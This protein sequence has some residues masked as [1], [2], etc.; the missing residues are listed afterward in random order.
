MVNA[1][2]G[3]GLGF[4]VRNNALLVNWGIWQGFLLA[5]ALPFALVHPAT[6]QTAHGLRN[7]QAAAKIDPAAPSPLSLAR[8]LWPTAPLEFQADDGKAVALLLANLALQDAAAGIDRQAL[9]AVAQVKAKARR[10]KLREQKQGAAPPPFGPPAAPDRPGFT[11]GP[12]AKPLTQALTY[13]VGQQ[14]QEGPQPLI[15]FTLEDKGQ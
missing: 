2:P 11:A 1:H 15:Y 13:Q 4:V 9:A 7:W 3:E 10:K 8:R 14:A 12:L 6:W 5:A